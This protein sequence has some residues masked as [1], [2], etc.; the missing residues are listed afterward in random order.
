MEIY[1]MHPSSVKGLAAEIT[2]VCNDYYAR[3]LSEQELKRVICHWANSYGTM[4]FAGP[5]CFNPT[6]MK[7]IGTKRL[8]LMETMLDGFQTSLM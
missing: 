1:I 6:I 3:K 5:N 4:L 7:I 8:R 2:K